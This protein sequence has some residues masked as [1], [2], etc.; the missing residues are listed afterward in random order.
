MTAP[1]NDTKRRS[2]LS[3]T[4]H[5]IWGAAMATGGAWAVV[6]VSRQRSAPQNAALIMLLVW[7]MLPVLM[8]SYMSRVVHPFYLLLTV[9]A[10]HGLAAIRIAPLLRRRSGVIG[11]LALIIVTGGINGLNTI[12]FAENTAAHPGEDLPTLPLQESLALGRRIRAERAPGMAMFSPMDEWTPVTLAGQVFHVETPDTFDHATVIPRKGGPYIT[13]Q[14]P[15]TE[16]AD[17]LSALP[18]VAQPI[19][20]PLVL[21]DGAVITLWRAQQSDADIPQAADI[22]S[23]IDVRFAGWGL[24]GDLLPSAVVTLDTYWLVDALHADRGV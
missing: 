19:A 21:D 6:Q 14:R 1:A 13:M 9:P 10:G 16:T 22:P 7:F 23:V 12:R 8:M 5:I 17:D 15:S 11:V 2:S 20:N 3:D 4:L 18:L 24:N